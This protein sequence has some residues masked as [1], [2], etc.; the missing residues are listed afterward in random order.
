MAFWGECNQA[1]IEIFINL[2]TMNANDEKVTVLY[3]N[4]AMLDLIW[5]SWGEND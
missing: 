4:E 3:I 1:I 5:Q 2:K